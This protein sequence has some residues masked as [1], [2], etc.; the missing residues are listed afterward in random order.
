MNSLLIWNK[1][2]GEVLACIQRP[3]GF[4]V[5]PTIQRVFSHLPELW[6]SLDSV[7]LEERLTTLQAKELYKIIDGQPVRQEGIEE[8]T[9]Q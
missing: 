8:P 1:E 7:W 9:D 4:V 3:R 5:E 2:T 6:E